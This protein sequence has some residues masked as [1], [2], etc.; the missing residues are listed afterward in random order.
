MRQTMLVFLHQ[1][2]PELVGP[3]TRA[4]LRSMQQ[5]A[6]KREDHVSLSDWVRGQHPEVWLHWR[7]TEGDTP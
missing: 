4:F 1:H 5:A 7:M 6:V 2:Y 3:L